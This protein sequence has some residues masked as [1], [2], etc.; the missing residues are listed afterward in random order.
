MFKTPSG[1][2]VVDIPIPKNVYRT[3]VFCNPKIRY[4]KGTKIS[5]AAYTRINKSVTR[6]PF[7]IS[8]CNDFGFKD[9]KLALQLLSRV[10]DS[11]VMLRIIR[12][13]DDEIEHTYIFDDIDICKGLNINHGL[14]ICQYKIFTDIIYDFLRSYSI[15]NFKLYNYNEWIY[16]TNDIRYIPIHRTRKYFSSN[17]FNSTIRDLN[18]RFGIRC[19]LIQEYL[20]SVRDTNVYDVLYMLRNFS[21]DIKCMIL[22]YMYL[23]LYC[24]ALDRLYIKHS[25]ESLIEKNTIWDCKIDCSYKCGLISPLHLRARE[26]NY[27]RTTHIELSE[28]Y[29]IDSKEVYNI[30]ITIFFGCHILRNNKFYI[31]G[32][33]AHV[34][35]LLYI[36]K[37]DDKYQ[38]L[39]DDMP[40]DFYDQFPEIMMDISLHDIQKLRNNEKFLSILSSMVDSKFIKSLYRRSPNYRKRIFALRD[41][42]PFLDSI[43][44]RQGKLNIQQIID[45]SALKKIFTYRPLLDTGFL[46]RAIVVKKSELNLKNL[47]NSLEMIKEFHKFLNT[48][49]NIDIDLTL[50]NDNFNYK[51][52]KYETIYTRRGIKN[53]YLSISIIIAII[54]NIIENKSIISPTNMK[55][56]RDTTYKACSYANAII[57]LR[58]IN[59]QLFTKKAR[60]FNSLKNF[61]QRYSPNYIYHRDIQRRYSSYSSYIISDVIEMLLEKRLIGKWVVQN[62]K[63]KNDTIIYKYIKDI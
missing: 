40:N 35:I 33:Q 7:A 21:N 18:S 12:Q 11:Y 31:D 38:G 15:E 30:I 1:F 42:I 26:Y 13:S 14:F 20:D 57:E 54:I 17:F 52:E 5:L 32:N 60:L 19:P 27:R 59:L 10:F 43:Y 62:G 55:I 22:Y 9:E 41:A 23:N 4:T 49:I 51:F 2:W 6:I 47:Y 56:N 48:Q 8:F 63:F 44:R 37:H 28:K 36:L 16:L 25:D 34:G 3:H 45:E 29:K 53:F 58:D 39:M 46:E 61:F 50:I 24:T